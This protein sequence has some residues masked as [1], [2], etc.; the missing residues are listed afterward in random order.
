M[1]LW[2]VNLE[3]VLST[4]IGSQE[5]SISNLNSR[6]AFFP[7]QCQRGY[8]GSDFDFFLEEDDSDSV[9]RTRFPSDTG[10]GSRGGS[11]S[12]ASRIGMFSRNSAT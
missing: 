7:L 8:G 9:E 5:G 1:C 4:K 10:S 11:G 3:V 2:P 12:I 6:L